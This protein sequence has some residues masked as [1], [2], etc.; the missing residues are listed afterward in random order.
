MPPPFI[1]HGKSLPTQAEAEPTPVG[2]DGAA[3]SGQR[4]PDAAARS[5]ERRDAV[6]SEQCERGEGQALQHGSGG[7]RGKMSRT[8][9]PEGS[10][11]EIPNFSAKSQPFEQRKTSTSTARSHVGVTK[12][13]LSEA[14][15]CQF[16][17]IQIFRGVT[18]NSEPLNG[19]S[20]VVEDKEALRSGMKIST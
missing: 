3:P 7:V 5:I 2:R 17:E 4:R 14:A 1:M 12:R 8:R 11:M 18:T 6:K 19:L 15:C 20:V 13:R 16:S 9:I 10:G